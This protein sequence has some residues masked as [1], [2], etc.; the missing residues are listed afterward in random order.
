MIIITKTTRSTTTIN[1]FN[2]TNIITTNTIAG[3]TAYITITTTMTTTTTTTTTITASNTTI[4]S[5][6]ILCCKTTLI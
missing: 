6:I 2:I 4:T 5:R 1:P 3:A